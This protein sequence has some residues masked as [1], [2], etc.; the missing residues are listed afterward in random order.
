MNCTRT[1]A[2]ALPVELQCAGG[3]HKVGVHALG[4]L[5]EEILVEWQGVNA[6]DQ[7]VATVTALLVIRAI[8]SGRRADARLGA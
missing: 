8:S 6:S 5:S 4:D 3:V 7:Q 1:W 2:Q